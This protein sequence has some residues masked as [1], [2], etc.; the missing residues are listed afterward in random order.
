MRKIN[1]ILLVIAA[2]IHFSGCVS[3]H[4]TYTK[5]SPGIWRG[6]LYLDSDVQASVNKKDVQRGSDPIGELPFNFEVIYDTPESFHIMIHNGEERIKITDVVF[7]RDRATAKDTLDIEFKEFD[8][9]IH[10]IVEEKLME[11]YWEVNYKEN[12]K[13]KFKAFQGDD[14]RFRQIS[15]K[16]PQDFSGRYALRFSPNSKDEYPGIGVF[17]QKADTLFGTVLTETGDYRYLA[18]KVVDNKA[19]LSVFDGSHSFLIEMKKDSL[20]HIIGA[21][22]YGT[23]GKEAFEG[24]LDPNAKLSSGYDLVK[25]TNK[26]KISF[27]LPNH[28][29]K[30]VN[31]NG[32]DFKGKVK[33]YEVMGTWCPNCKDATNFLKKVKAENPDIAIAALAF[34]RYRDSTKSTKILSQYVTKMQL[35]Y[36]ILLAGY[37]DKKEASTKL[38]M[39]EKVMAY[40]TLL[41]VDQND[42]LQKIFTGFYGPATKE[43]ESFIKEFQTE[44]NK[45]RKQ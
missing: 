43:H 19:Y 28:E 37:F 32:D 21:I 29:G 11:G 24:I 12:Y 27:N 18:G 8:T 10:A 31:T 35:T 1:F 22:R 4:Q 17:E 23:A 6:V 14:R 36:P 13:I 41:I 26:N 33:I 30:L 15:P 34:E 20:N 5:I 40:P 9:K 16:A 42:Q 3:P 38:P 45:L 2:F 44:L 7:G 25:Q 39:I